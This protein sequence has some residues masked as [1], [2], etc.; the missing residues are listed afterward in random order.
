VGLS[1]LWIVGGLGCGDAP[2]EVS[3]EADAGST[4][5]AA[6]EQDPFDGE[7]VLE[8]SLELTDEDWEAAR[9]EGR[10][11]ARVLSGCGDP[12]FDYSWVEAAVTIGDETV[13][14]AG[15]HK[16]GFLGSLSTKRPSLNVDFSRFVSGQGLLGLSRMTLNNNRQ[17]PTNA[18]QCL[19]Y[20]LFRDAGLRAPRC[21]I[22]HVRVNGEDL[23]YFSHVEPIKKPFLERAFGD[24]SGNLYEG[25]GTDFTAELIS[26]IEKKTNE[27][28]ADFSDVEQLV[29]ALEVDDEQLLARLAEHLDVARFI[30]FWALETLVGHW[31]GYTGNANNFMLYKNPESGLFEFIPWGADGAFGEHAFIPD[32]PPS[33][34]VTT[35]LPRRLYALAETR[36]AYEAELRDLLEHVWDEQR[37][38]DML[39]TITAQTGVSSELSRLVRLREFI[40]GRRAKIETDL[41]EGDESWQARSPFS[42]SCNYV[43]EPFSLQFE[44][45]WGDA[46]AYL[47]NPAIA[48]SLDLAGQ[49]RP[50][51]TLLAAAGLVDDENTRGPVIRVLATRSGEPFTLV[52]FSL[53]EAYVAPGRYPIHAFETFGIVGLTSGAG[54]FDARAV[55]AGGELVLEEASTEDGARIVGSFEGELA[56]L[57][58]GLFDS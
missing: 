36:E 6:P 26:R 47:P 9:A 44:A 19:A 27:R 23:G 54:Q 7:S 25:Q 21:A 43:A 42:S 48:L 18:R 55:L 40:E 49:G 34:L 50:F 12:S 31:D 24:D 11:A 2:E 32:Y 33:R 28:E 39:D 1:S 10:D 41:A 20:R 38:L 22:A 51:D 5:D 58:D 17:D 29:E 14:R 45:A 57:P 37:L 30:R 56:F 52:Q 53:P 4:G 46:S 3:G 35:I 15:V 13:T 8:V 16:K